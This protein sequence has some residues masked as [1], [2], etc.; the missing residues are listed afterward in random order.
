MNPADMNPADVNPADVNPHDAHYSPNHNPDQGT[1]QGYP[2]DSL[3]HNQRRARRPNSTE[4]LFRS[5][6]NRVW[7][8]V[9]GGMGQYVGIDPMLLRVG[10]V[11]IT[12]ITAG[13]A[14]IGYGL[15]WWL[16]PQSNN[17]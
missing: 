16:I 2:P 11:L 8:G 1:H 5:R 3:Q 7:G 4:R 10:Y 9:L 13:I 12:L 6:T 17:P 14:A 15:L